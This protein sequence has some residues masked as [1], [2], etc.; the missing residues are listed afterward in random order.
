MAGNPGPDDV[1][2][3][4][5]RDGDE[6]ALEPNR[7]MGRLNPDDGREGDP[8][9]SAWDALTPADPG[10]GAGPDSYGGSGTPRGGE[11]LALVPP[12]PEAS[13]SRAVARRR[14]LVVSVVAIGLG[15]VAVCS[16]PVVWSETE[17]DWMLG[18]ATTPAWYLFPWLGLA[19]WSPSTSGWVLFGLGLAM[20][21]LGVLIGRGSV[22]AAVLAP[23]IVAVETLRI[24]TVTY[25]YLLFGSAGLVPALLGRVALIAFLGWG[26]WAVRS[27]RRAG[28]AV[29]AGPGTGAGRTSLSSLARRWWSVGVVLV[30]ALA[31]VVRGG[32]LGFGGGGGSS[33]PA[34]DPRVIA[35]VQTVVEGRAAL[36]TA[37]DLLYVSDWYEGQVL[38]IDT[39]TNQLVDTFPAGDMPGDVAVDPD[40]HALYVTFEAKDSV[41]R[42]DT[43]SHG[44]VAEVSTEDDPQ[45]VEVDRLA[46]IAC[47]TNRLGQSVTLVNTVTASVAATIPLP[48]RPADVAVDETTHTAYVVGDGGLSLIN[49]VTGRVIRTF[50]LPGIDPTAVALD[51]PAHLA[52]VLDEVTETDNLAIVDTTAGTVVATARV[53]KWPQ[54]VAV[55]PTTDTVYTANFGDETVSVID[56][57][58]RRV[59]DTVLTPDGASELVV[60][61]DTHLLYVQGG[62]Y[63]SVVALNPPAEPTTSSPTP[64]SAAPSTPSQTTESPNTQKVTVKPVRHDDYYYDDGLSV[65]DCLGDAFST[66]VPC[67]KKHT[68]EVFALGVIRAKAFPGEDQIKTVADPFC[69]AGYRTYLKDPDAAL[70]VWSWWAPSEQT[71]KAGNRTLICA[72]ES[73]PPTKGSVR[74]H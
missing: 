52:Y 41:W 57:T 34:P 74:D 23:G 60:D 32:L 44:K 55:D 53:G 46:H 45:R 67:A 14:V 51:A 26:I 17:G 31:V 35:R 5:R 15:L 25:V 10:G 4:Y 8:E 11:A 7:A 9:A 56:T 50:A 59:V 36:D 29:P 43:S 72:I 40:V 6:W 33:A 73:D 42:Y 69:L 47:V 65:G 71:W 62:L 58:T 16:A 13:R 68:A 12:D 22:L 54:D 37:A 2:G 3:G 38:V 66:V 64:N 18:G 24:A 63:L 30:V 28:A 70:D 61:P 49:L 1:A 39:T 48:G 21:A 19:G 20:A 27:S